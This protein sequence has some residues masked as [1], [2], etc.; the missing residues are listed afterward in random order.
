[1]SYQAYVLRYS[2]PGQPERAIGVFIYDPVSL[3]LRWRLPAQWDFVTDEWDREVL[4]SLQG[5]F[6]GMAN[7]L[8]GTGLLAYLLD[9]LSNV[10]RM[11]HPHSID[12]ESFDAA[13]NE[14]YDRY[15]VFSR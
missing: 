15:V 1:M 3:V 9:T 14:A 4:Q 8:G 2:P 11:S 10:L 7:E 5:D 13:V 12:A 6:E